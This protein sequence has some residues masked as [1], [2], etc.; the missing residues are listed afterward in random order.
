M[1][2]KKYI[3]MTLV[4]ASTSSIAEEFPKLDEAYP[5]NINIRG[6]E[7]VFDFDTDGCYPA[8]GISRSGVKNPGLK[9]SGALNGSCRDAGFLEISNTL[10]RYACI[11]G[12][13]GTYCAQVYDM[14]FEKDQA[15]N[16]PV[17]LGHRHDWETVTVWTLNGAITHV[18]A[19][20]HG[21]MD[22]KP[23]G[24]IAKE[25][26]HAKIVYHKSGSSTHAFRFASSTEPPENHYQYWVTP[27]VT[28]WYELRGD[29]ISNQD[30]RNRL[31]SFDYGDASIKVKDSSFLSSI[32]S[33]KPS[34]YPTFTQS[35]V[36]ASN[37]NP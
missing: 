22:V 23:F 32:N 17:G 8:A 31:N 9:T 5:S 34:G 3:F 1:K 37:P 33:W 2:N 14:Y 4:L 13:G 18:G 6:F 27:A 28:T 10:H 25:G 20:A 35:S 19:S 30:M 16:G 21:K 11:P 29:G 36:E 26:N 7:P 24:E 15:Q 12:S